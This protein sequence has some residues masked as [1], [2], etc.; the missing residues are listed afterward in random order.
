MFRTPRWYSH[1][2]INSTPHE[3]HL[4][5]RDTWHERSI[6]FLGAAETFRV[7]QSCQNWPSRPKIMTTSSKTWLVGL[8]LVYHLMVLFCS[9]EAWPR[10]PWISVRRLKLPST[11]LPSWPLAHSRMVTVASTGTWRLGLPMS[12]TCRT[13]HSFGVTGPDFADIRRKLSTNAFA[14]AND[15]S[16]PGESGLTGIAMD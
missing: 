10:I 14:G 9:R 11:G 5:C 1:Y 12:P 7:V 6:N 8:Q 15:Y 16:R 2:Y 13:L 4:Y 3:A